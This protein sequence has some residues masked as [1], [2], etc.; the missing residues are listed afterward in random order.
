MFGEL[1]YSVLPILIHLKDTSQ[2]MNN[3]TYNLILQ[4]IIK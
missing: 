1:R 4:R 3:W 2:E